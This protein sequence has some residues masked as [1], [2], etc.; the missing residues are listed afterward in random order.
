[1]SRF[2]F[3]EIHLD[4]YRCFD[5]LTFPLEEDTTVLFTEN[6]GGT[7]PVHERS[8]EREHGEYR[9]KRGV[10]ETHDALAAAAAEGV[11]YRSPLGPPRRTA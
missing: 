10:L 2:R 3:R 11:P 1:M 9:T 5:E 6:G 8:E 7:F 4:N